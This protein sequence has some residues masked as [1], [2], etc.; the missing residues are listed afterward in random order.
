MTREQLAERIGW[1]KIIWLVG[2]AN[3]FFM[4]PQLV[5][6][7]T[8]GATEGISIIT[9]VMLVILQCGFALHGF[10]L[11]DKPL[12][13]SNGAAGLVS[14]ITTLSVLYFRV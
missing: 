10:F 3:P 14:L 7:W 13:V 8:T 1:S 5:G 12:M 6:I 4:F 11:R 2:I 9:L